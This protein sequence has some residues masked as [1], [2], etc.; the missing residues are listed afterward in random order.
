MLS[1]HFLGAV[2]RIKL[3]IGDVALSLDTFNDPTR[4]PPVAGETI[5][6]HFAPQTVLALT[7]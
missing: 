6:I 3:A 7:D 4:P 2:I 1:V 5:Q